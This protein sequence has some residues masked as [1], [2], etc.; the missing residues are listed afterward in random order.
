MS[1]L[2]P[3]ARSIPE[4]WENIL[5][6]VDSVIDVPQDRWD[7]RAYYDSDPFVPDKVY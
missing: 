7:T 2:M 6:K 1:C 5:H 4:F 3:D